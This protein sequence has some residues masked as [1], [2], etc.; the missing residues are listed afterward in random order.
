MNF[1]KH[2]FN[3]TGI[4]LNAEG[5]KIDKEFIELVKPFVE[6]YCA[7]YNAAEFEN[8]LQGTLY[9]I[10]VLGKAVKAE[11]EDCEQDN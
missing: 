6:K 7:E 3:S 4:V 1:K 2:L 11:Q 10:M 5:E 9:G 8:L